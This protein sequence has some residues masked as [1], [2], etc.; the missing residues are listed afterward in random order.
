MQRVFLHAGNAPHVPC[1]ITGPTSAVT[2]V[3]TYLASC[4]ENAVV[5]RDG[6]FLVDFPMLLSRLQGREEESAAARGVTPIVEENS[7]SQGGAGH[8]PSPPF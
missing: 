5:E 7:A 3:G 8:G 2:S 1:L 4:C 6:H